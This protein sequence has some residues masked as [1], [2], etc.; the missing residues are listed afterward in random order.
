MEETH[1]GDATH[2]GLHAL[3]T[4]TTLGGRIH[5]A[6]LHT[7]SLCMIDSFKPC[8]R[9]TTWRHSQTGKLYEFDF[10]CASQE[11]RHQFQTPVTFTCAISDHWGKQVVMHLS[12][13]GKHQL[14]VRRRERFRHFQRCK[15]LQQAKGKL[16]VQALRGPSEAAGCK[17]QQF[18]ES[19]EHR[20]EDRGAP[21]PPEARPASPPVDP[22]CDVELYTDGSHGEAGTTASGW[23]LFVVSETRRE[24]YYAPVCTDETKR[25]FHGAEGHSNNVAELEAIGMALKWIQR[26]GTPNTNAPIRYDSQYAAGTRAQQ[27]MLLWRST[28]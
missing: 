23:G 13:P 4:P 17:R 3:S 26:F 19:V 18:R 16:N 8:A 21:L 15:E 22:A 1:P 27:K 2:T 28:Q 7:T 10:V 25:D 24:S 14:R 5:R 11:I 20:L 12:A 6:W 9:R